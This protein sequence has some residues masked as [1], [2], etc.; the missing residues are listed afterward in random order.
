MPRVTIKTII[1]DGRDDW[2]DKDYSTEVYVDG[3]KI[4]QG[5]YGGEPE[6]N[7]YHRDYSWVEPLLIKLAGQLGAEV[8]LE[9]SKSKRD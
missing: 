1:R 2:D 7:S 5:F 3:I 8:I 9:E 6:D 4:G